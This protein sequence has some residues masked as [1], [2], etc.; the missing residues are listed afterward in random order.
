MDT[1]AWFAGSPVAR[2]ATVAPD[3]TPH[4]VPVVFA[5]DGDVIYTGV[6][7][8]PKKTR[9]LRRLAN[10]EHNP[11]VSLLVDHYAPDWS[12]LWWVRVD[13]TATV[14]TEGD[15]VRTGYRL[16]LAKYPQYQSVPLDGPVIVVS[17]TRWSGWHA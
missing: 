9:R 14:A 8:K 5:V 6:D 15:A 12:Q 17:A 3:G 13:G 1:R 11:A 16:L 4:L 7:A 2:L 10:I